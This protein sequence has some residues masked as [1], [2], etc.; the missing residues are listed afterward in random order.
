MGSS[1]FKD[2]DEDFG[3]GNEP[4]LTTKKEKLIDFNEMEF[5]NDIRQNND[6]RTNVD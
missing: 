2:R 3:S 1:F 5:N 6:F 4:P